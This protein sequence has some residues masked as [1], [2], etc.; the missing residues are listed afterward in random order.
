MSSEV[1]GIH[2]QENDG[3]S[4]RE[5]PSDSPQKDGE[6][7]PKHDLSLLFSALLTYSGNMFYPVNFLFLVENK[8]SFYKE[9][10]IA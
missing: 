7:R 9:I 4:A 1:L 3:S 5:T 2:M 8:N 10:L 6:L